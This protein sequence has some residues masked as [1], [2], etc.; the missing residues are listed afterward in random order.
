[1]L[2]LLL[3][4]FTFAADLSGPLGP[5]CEAVSSYDTV[6]AGAEAITTQIQSLRETIANSGSAVINLEKEK[7]LVLRELEFLANEGKST[8]MALFSERVSLEDYFHLETR[9]RSWQEN[10]PTE[11]RIRFAEKSDYLDSRLAEMLHAQSQMQ[12]EID[13]LGVR[14][15]AHLTLLNAMVPQILQHETLCQGACSRERCSGGNNR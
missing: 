6:Q 13:A 4:S 2:F 15:E 8:P 12:H 11:R 14:H 1:M 3:S 5:Y 7:N 10:Y 9:Q